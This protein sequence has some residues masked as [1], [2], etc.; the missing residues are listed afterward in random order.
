VAGTAGGGS[1]LGC[2]LSRGLDNQSSRGSGS[3]VDAGAGGRL[4]EFA[5]RSRRGGN[6]GGSSLLGLGRVEGLGGG[7]VYLDGDGLNLSNPLDNEVTLIMVMATGMAVRLGNGSRGQGEK[8]DGSRLHCGGLGYQFLKQD[9]KS[10]RDQPG[11]RS[12]SRL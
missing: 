11:S 7:L 12:V 9:G 5:R 3:R 8:C 2:L 1:S 6:S 10:Q 4:E